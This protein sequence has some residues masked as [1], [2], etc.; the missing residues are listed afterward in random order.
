MGNIN[1]V[2]PIR[3]QQRS[4]LSECPAINKYAMSE[5]LSG[6]LIAKVL[7]SLGG[8][9]LSLAVLLPGNKKEALLRLVAGFMSGM[10]F[11]APTMGWLGWEGTEYLLSASALAGFSG[12][13][14]FGVVSRSATKW[15]T[16]QDV[17]QEAN[18]LRKEIK[19]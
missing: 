16:I 2:L 1:I 8:T 6:S 14:V 10:M 9:A 17:V 18:S 11:G 7:G 12:W 13:F 5:L 3:D 15:R 4:V 19:K